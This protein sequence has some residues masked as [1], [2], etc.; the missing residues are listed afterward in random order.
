MCKPQV[1]AE[2]HFINRLFAHSRLPLDPNGH[3]VMICKTDL[4]Q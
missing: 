3:I 1:E 4:Q 2:W